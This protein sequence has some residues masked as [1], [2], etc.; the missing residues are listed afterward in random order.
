VVRDGASGA[1]KGEPQ[2][3]LHQPSAALTAIRASF[4]TLNANGRLRGC[5]GSL[6]ARFPLV[7]DVA[8]NAFRSA[9]HD[10]RFA[11]VSAAEVDG[12]E[13]KIS[14]L[15]KPAEIP[16]ASEDELVRSL[17]PGTDGLILAD[18]SSRGTFLPQAW[19]S[20][21]VP[22][23]FVRRLKMKAGLPPDHWSPTLKVWRYATETFAEGG[24]SLAG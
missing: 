20:I 15:S 22:A 6:E 5:I 23:E 21:P 17:M 19:E 2:V 3:T 18:G 14:V 9:F 1:L 7:Q 4:V 24:A 13:T 10:P 11:K 8:R 12:L 16:F